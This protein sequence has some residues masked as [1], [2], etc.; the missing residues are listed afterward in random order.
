MP[1]EHVAEHA[2]S[3]R[4]LGTWIAL[5][6]LTTLSF[7][8]SYARTGAWE[9]PIA[10]VIAVVKSVLVLLFFMHLIEQRL[11]N[12][13]T[14]VV[15]VGLLALLMSLVAADV[16]TRRTF[17]RTPLPEIVPGPPRVSPPP[18]GG[19]PGPPPWP[20]PGGL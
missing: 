2:P 14:V 9:L 10:L 11:I 1:G 13:F 18:P 16:L 20:P 4:Y 8:L 17:P 12:A 5:L 6:A 3:S 7:G 15:A 19:A